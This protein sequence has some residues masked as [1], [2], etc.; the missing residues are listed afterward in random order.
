MNADVFGLRR[1][2][3]RHAA[4][5]RK[6]VK[7][8]RCRHEALPPHA[9]V[10]TCVPW[11]SVAVSFR[12]NH[13]SDLV[14][15]FL[16]GGET[17]VFHRSPNMAWPS[18]SSRAAYRAVSSGTIRCAASNSIAVSPR[19]R[20][21]KVLRETLTGI[22]RECVCCNMRPWKKPASARQTPSTARRDDDTCPSYENAPPR[23][24]LHNR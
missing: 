21:R 4:L 16:V 9:K 14:S 2:A 1:E 23:C 24:R 13:G 20:E 8:D 17:S 11:R 12:F 18:R 15:G 22:S 6:P 7:E 19:R 3:Q 10:L 5:G